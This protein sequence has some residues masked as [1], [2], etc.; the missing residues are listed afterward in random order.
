MAFPRA[1]R[2]A[3]PE[4]HDGR[5]LEL[6]SVLGQVVDHPFLGTTIELRCAVKET[7]RLR[8]EFVVRVG[9]QVEAAR[10]LAATLVRLA[11]EAENNPVDTSA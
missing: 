5:E 9:L 8:G 6:E 4:L 2:D 3:I 10:G 7:G 1:L 11:D